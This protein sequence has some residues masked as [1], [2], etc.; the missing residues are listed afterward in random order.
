MKTRAFA[1]AALVAALQARAQQAPDPDNGAITLPPG[2][3][4][5]VFADNLGRLRFLTVAPNGDVYV[6]TSTGSGILALR[7]DDRDGRAETKA[8][9]GDSTGT[10]VEYRDGF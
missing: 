2:F 4:A 7:D 8:V 9:I 3:R 10:G 6:K 5:T 1:A